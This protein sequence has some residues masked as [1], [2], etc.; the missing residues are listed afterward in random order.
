MPVTV[1]RGTLGGIACGHR[2]IRILIERN[3]L[4]LTGAAALSMSSSVVVVLVGGIVGR[5]LAPSPELATLPVSAMIVGTALATVPAALLMQR[6]GRRRGLSLAA[7]LGAAAALAAALAIDAGSFPLLCAATAA[8]GGHLAFAQQYRFAAAESVPV[9]RAGRAVSTVLLGPI[10]AA[11]MGPAVARWLRD[12][13]GLAEHAGGFV[14]IAALLVAAAL[15]L[16]RLRP[17]GLPPAPQH[18]PM[19]RWR[20]MMGRGPVVL[21][22]VSAVVAYGTMSFLM[23][24]TPVSMHVVDGHSLEEAAWV[25][26][27]HVMAM[28]LPSLLTGWLIVRLGIVRILGLGVAILG[29]SV[30]SALGG[31][32]V[33]SY[34][35]ALVLLGIGW[36][37]LFVGATA[38]LARQADPAERF[39]L[40]A[41]NDFAVF[42]TTALSS[43][44]SGVVM[45]RFGWNVLVGSTLPVLA[46][47]AFLVAV[48][49]LRSRRAGE[50]VVS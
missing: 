39:R 45:S 2:R 35:W 21:A 34:W 50:P 23:T 37:L 49:W 33:S 11:W 28:Y 18:A 42:G 30:A 40:Q 44:M 29:G 32:A 7:L 9:Q 8:V 25:V 17:S 22:I 14:G 5:E 38:L 27:S 13:F 20:A 41:V 1:D 26:Q 47:L 15:V 31:H 36:N 3:V 16:G 4:L 24:A 10:L 6:I 43:L 19:G 48:Y 12:A 46:A